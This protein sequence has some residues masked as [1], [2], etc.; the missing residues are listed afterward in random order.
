MIALLLALA[1]TLSP[2]HPVQAEV[3]DGDQ[4]AQDGEDVAEL[5]GTIPAWFD[6]DVDGVGGGAPVFIAGWDDADPLL[7]STS[8]DCDDSR[9][10]ISPGA[11]D[12]CDGIDNN[13]DGDPDR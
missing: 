7:V 4:D 10:D 9:S 8:G 3:P 6:L 11:V 12:A 1:C 2:A 13:C 5:L